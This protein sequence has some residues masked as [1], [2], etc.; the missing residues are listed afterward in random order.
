MKILF[1]YLSLFLVPA[2]LAQSH[3][4]MFQPNTYM[5]GVHMEKLQVELLRPETNLTI[6]KAVKID[7]ESPLARLKE[8]QVKVVYL[9]KS[10]VT[11]GFYLTGDD[12]FRIFSALG[13][14]KT[15][16]AIS[17]HDSKLLKYFPDDLRPKYLEIKKVDYQTANQLFAKHNYVEA[18]RI[19]DK[20]LQ[21]IPNGISKMPQLQLL[22]LKTPKVN[23][24]PAVS[25]PALVVLKA[26]LGKV[27]G[28]PHALK[29][30]TQLKYLEL[31]GTASLKEIPYA[32]TELKDLEELHLDTRYVKEWPPY[33]M[34]L[35]QLKV[36]N[37]TDCES[38]TKIP[39]DLGKLTNLE[40][41]SLY[42]LNSYTSWDFVNGLSRPL[43]IYLKGTNYLRCLKRLENSSQ[44]EL[45]G[46]GAEV[47]SKDLA[48]LQERL[49]ANKVMKQS[50]N[51]K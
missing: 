18:L 1:T 20:D 42:N 41:L 51:Q 13:E 5:E 7:G 48:K 3:H 6:A 21:H 25:F 8:S 50:Y 11:N 19:E 43:K 4:R 34:D 14:L 44:I 28:I 27:I 35:Q 12:L 2:L 31:K 38:L 47:Y 45:I 17:L 23:S 30:S 33:L 10:V 22:E 49:E 29:G 46:L 37:F 40:V 39:A 16:E 26:S 24:F 36:I 32:L 9:D 15:I